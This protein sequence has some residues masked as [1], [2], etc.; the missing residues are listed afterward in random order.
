MKHVKLTVLLISFFMCR[1]DGVLAQQH[2][3]ELEER[4]QALENY[5]EGFQPTLNKFSQDM[6]NT[7]QSYH[8]GLE[9][10]LNKYYLKLQDKLDQRLSTLDNRT[11]VLDSSGKTFQRLDTDS[12][13]FLISIEKLERIE[14][15]VRLHMNIGNINF[16][17]FADYKIKL[18]WGKKWTGGEVSDSY[19]A[20]RQ[21]LTGAEFLFQGVLIKGVWNPIKIDLVPADLSQVE[22]IECGMDV[23]TVILE[24]K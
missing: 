23:S 15:G 3:T 20:W 11:I 22:Y 13:M 2:K 18:V 19:S 1:A 16:A 17:D 14:N 12:G 8:Q 6:Q 9:S 7:V 24:H 10:D 4:V 21:G 5:I